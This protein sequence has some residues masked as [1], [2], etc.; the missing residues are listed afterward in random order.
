MVSRGSCWQGGV[1]TD[2]AL[3]LGTVGGM[4]SIQDWTV[5]L[6]RIELNL[7]LAGETSFSGDVSL[8]PDTDRIAL[9][10]S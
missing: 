3:G 5:S 9:I 2:C 7:G 6:S 4:V 1:A 8:I 10:V